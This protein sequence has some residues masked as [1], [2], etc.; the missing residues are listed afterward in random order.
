MGYFEP[1]VIEKRVYDNLA[2]PVLAKAASHLQVRT[3]A[4]WTLT[5]NML[6]FICAANL[7]QSAIYDATLGSFFI[8]FGH[9]A[10]E[11]FKYKSVKRGVTFPAIVSTTSI[12]WMLS[13]RDAYIN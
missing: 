3:F 9:F 7:G 8:A 5:S 4:T 11:F 10:L 2:R 13:R 6:C 1:S 12:A